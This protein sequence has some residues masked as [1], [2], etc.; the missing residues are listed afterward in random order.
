MKV[1]AIQDDFYGLGPNPSFAISDPWE[2]WQWVLLTLGLGLGLGLGCWGC[3]SSSREPLGGGRLADPQPL[4]DPTSSREQPGGRPAD[5]EFPHAFPNAS[6]ANEDIRSNQAKKRREELIE[7]SL[8][9]HQ[10][11]ALNTK[12]FQRWIRRFDLPTKRDEPI[13]AAGSAPTKEKDNAKIG[14]AQT[15]TLLS[16]AS[17]DEDCTIARQRDK[18]ANGAIQDSA[19]LSYAPSDD[20]PSTASKTNQQISE[21][22][23]SEDSNG[24]STD[25]NSVRYYWKL[26]LGKG[27]SRDC[28]SI[29]LEPYQFGDNVARLKKKANGRRSCKHWFHKNCIHE[30]LENHDECPLCR[31]KIVKS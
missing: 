26:L 29:C 12:Q 13:T 25:S 20:D 23:R 7:S 6:P 21:W 16:Y 30:W 1:Y 4:S 22:K 31:V 10:I 28:C 9:F 11:G 3:L 27:S 2:W 8:E 17:S 5:Q 18:G 15:P 19:L 14:V 24:R